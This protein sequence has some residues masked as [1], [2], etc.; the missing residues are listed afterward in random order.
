[1]NGADVSLFHWINGWSDACAPFYHFL[2][3]GNKM[4]SVRIVFGLILIAMIVA[5]IR[6]RRAALLAVLSVPLA[7]LICDLLKNNLQMPRPCPPNGKETVFYHGAIVYNHGVGFLG[8]YGTASAHAA[9]TSAIATVFFFFLARNTD[10]EAE[11][12]PLWKRAPWAVI[13]IL[14]SFLTGI[15]RIY[16]GVHYPSQ[17]LFGWICGVS[18]G[19]VVCFGYTYL[20]KYKREPKAV[21]ENGT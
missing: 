16:V 19:L 18:I 1:V 15:A 3:E 21:D 6:T 10:D 9:N 17:V 12:R 20:A 7:N 14:I 11:K 5:G 13:P 2:S 8:S 4:W